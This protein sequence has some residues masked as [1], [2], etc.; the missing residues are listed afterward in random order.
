MIAGDFLSRDILRAEPQSSIAEVRVSLLPARLS[1]HTEIPHRES[2]TWLAQW[3][4]SK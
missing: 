1:W 4:P 2:G 3:L